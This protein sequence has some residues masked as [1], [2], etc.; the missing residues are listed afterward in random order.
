MWRNVKKI[1]F[2]FWTNGHSCTKGRQKGRRIFSSVSINENE[3][4]SI[5]HAK[6]LVNVRT[7]KRGALVQM[8]Y[9]GHGIYLQF[10]SS[11]NE[12]NNRLYLEIMSYRCLTGGLA[13]DP[14]IALHWASWA[15]QSLTVNEMSWSAFAAFPQSLCCTS[16]KRTPRML[17]SRTNYQRQSEF[18]YQDR[19]NAFCLSSKDEFPSTKNSPVP[20]SKTGGAGM[21]PKAPSNVWRLVEIE[22]LVLAG[23]AVAKIGLVWKEWS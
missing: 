12:Y 18:T 16:L 14:A 19:V 9:V 22:L 5:S 20:V 15:S 3:K 6:E 21:L 2:F 23:A 7:F 8:F 10:L 17:K 4:S 13:H 1:W 11:R